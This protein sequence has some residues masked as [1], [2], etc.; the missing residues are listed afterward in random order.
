M[1]GESHTLL[2]PSDKEALVNGDTIRFDGK[3]EG[4]HNLDI[5]AILGSKEGPQY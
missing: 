1:D 2:L 5:S 4:V 3:L